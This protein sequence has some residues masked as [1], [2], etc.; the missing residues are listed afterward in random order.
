LACKYRFAVSVKPVAALIAL[1]LAV[2]GCSEASNGSLSTVQSASKASSSAAHAKAIEAKRQ[3]QL[4][5][6]YAAQAKQQQ[7]KAFYA[8]IAKKQQLDDF[9]AAVTRQ[10]QEQAAAQAAA[11]QAA[12]ANAE[13]AC[14][15]HDAWPGDAACGPGS[16]RPPAQQALPP[17]P[18]D[19]GPISGNWC[20]HS[21]NG[22]DNPGYVMLCQIPGEPKSSWPAAVDG[23]C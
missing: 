23:K 11:E 4:K 6:F 2:A 20:E 21:A 10:Q 19:Q 1:L 3:Q 17:C 14:S 7:L 9:Y 5:A 16:V 15:D 8:A 12:S 18:T 22:P 13:W